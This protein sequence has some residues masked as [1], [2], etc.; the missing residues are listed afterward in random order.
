MVEQM[1]TF[2]VSGFA[3]PGLSGV[4][5]LVGVSLGVAFGASGL[6]VTDHP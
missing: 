6:L 2:F 4:K 1:V 3:Y 5:I